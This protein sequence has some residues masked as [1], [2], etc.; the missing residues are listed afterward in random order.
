MV[1]TQ[2]NQVHVF[3]DGITDMRVCSF[4]ERKVIVISSS[5]LSCILVNYNDLTATSL[6]M[7]SMGDYPQMTFFQV[8]VSF[9][10]H[11]TFAIDWGV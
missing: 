11:V 4:W 5:G 7:D 2:A 6:G 9:I 1:G 3:N 8:S 10:F